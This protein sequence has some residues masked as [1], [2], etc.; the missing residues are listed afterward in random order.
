MKTMKRQ[1]HTPALPDI[2]A[3]AVALTQVSSSTVQEQLGMKAFLT[4]SSDSTQGEQ[5]E[6]E[7]A[8]PHQHHPAALRGSSLR[9]RLLFLT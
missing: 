4:S 5:L 2:G 6:G 7:A 3:P 9:A 1:S 8:L